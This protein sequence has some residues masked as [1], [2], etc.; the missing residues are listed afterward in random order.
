VAPPFETDALS[1]LLGGLG[2]AAVGLMAATSSD[3]A[4]RGLGL[5]RWRALHLA[6]GWYVWGIFTGTLAPAVLASPAHAA[7]F[8]LCLAVAGLRLGAW[9]ASR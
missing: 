9:R 7:E 3:A 5:R 1:F 4:Q 8:A 6:C 2:Y